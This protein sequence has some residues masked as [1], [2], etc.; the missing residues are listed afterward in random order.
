MNER[1]QSLTTTV[2]SI[3]ILRLRYT[4][5]DETFSPRS[6]SQRSQVM[7]MSKGLVFS[8]PVETTKVSSSYD[9]LTLQGF[10]AIGSKQKAGKIATKIG[11]VHV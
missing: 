6:Q 11:T 9:F 10:E 3:P 7:F 1:E 4:E 8:N 2:I 5:E